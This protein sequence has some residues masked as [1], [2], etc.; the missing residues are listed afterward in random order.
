MWKKNGI[1][2]FYIAK[3]VAVLRFGL[4]YICLVDYVNYYLFVGTVFLIN[5]KFKHHNHI[6]KVTLNKQPNRS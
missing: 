6:K 5:F 4:Q 1:A 3:Y 2:G